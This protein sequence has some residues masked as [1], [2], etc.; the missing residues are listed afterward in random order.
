MAKVK[1]TAAQA[2]GRAG[3]DLMGK[4]ER[5]SAGQQK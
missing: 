3:S 2:V 1:E 5:R 4:T